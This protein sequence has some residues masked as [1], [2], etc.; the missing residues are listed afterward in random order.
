MDA[1]TIITVTVMTG[2]ASLLFGAILPSPE[3]ARDREQEPHPDAAAPAAERELT[4]DELAEQTRVPSRTIRFYQSEGA[5]PKPTIRGRVAYYGQAHVER[6]AQITELQDR[7]LRIRAIRD[8]LARTA[9]GEFS[10]N[11]WIGSHDQL[12]SPWASDRP[13]VMTEAELAA[14]LE[15]RRPGLLG[16][17]VRVG[18]IERRGDA[19]LVESPARLGLLLR[20]DAVGMPLHTAEG[21]FALMQKQLGRLAEDLTSYFVKNAD[22]LGDDVDATYAELRPV[23]LEAVRLVFAREMER[24][25]RR[26]TES[27]AAAVLTKQ[28]RQRT[29][30]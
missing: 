19:Y 22:A 29:R 24:S 11:E 23:S 25:Q 20:L 7:G 15:G 21:A 16:E 9:K 2:A 28:K 8:V 4:I 17:L 18:A 27:G 13:K 14:E 12:S 26:A 10:L 30:R 1:V 3:M 6:L 5:L